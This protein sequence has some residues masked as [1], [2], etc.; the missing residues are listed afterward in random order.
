MLQTIDLA[1]LD[2]VHGGSALHGAGRDFGFGAGVVVTGAL[3]AVPGWNRQ[4]PGQPAG[5]EKRH[6]SVVGP[7]I[8][9]Y[10]N[11]LSAGPWKDFTSGVGEGATAAPGWSFHHG[12]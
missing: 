6:E 11:G 2:T 9:S 7:K 12:L 3:S 10:A 5:F 1:A 8:T 4:V